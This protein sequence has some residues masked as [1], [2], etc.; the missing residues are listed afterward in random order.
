LAIAGRGKVLPPKDLPDAKQG[1]P[2]GCTEDVQNC[3]QS[4]VLCCR[5]ETLRLLP[6]LRAWGFFI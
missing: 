6:V 3:H 4:M 1:K 5:E 2:W